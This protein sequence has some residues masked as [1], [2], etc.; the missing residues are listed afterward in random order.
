[1]RNAV[2]VYNVQVLNGFLVLLS[3]IGG[4]LGSNLFRVISAAMI[5]T[6]IFWARFGRAGR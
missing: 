3:Q 6:E 5:I 1:M 4:L 2:Q